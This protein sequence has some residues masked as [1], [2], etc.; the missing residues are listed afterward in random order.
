VTKSQNK[1]ASFQF[2]YEFQQFS[3]RSSTASLLLHI[4]HNPTNSDDSV[5]FT[6]CKQR[7]KTNNRSNTLSALIASDK[8]IRL[9]RLSLLGSANVLI[10]SSSRPAAANPVKSAAPLLLFAHQLGDVSAAFA[11]NGN[12][13]SVH[14]LRKKQVNK[15]P[16][17]D[18]VCGQSRERAH[19]TGS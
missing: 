17:S 18:H 10:K 9:S 7:R 6:S 2:S 19:Q 4:P 3:L 14:L 5:C 1:A 11:F 12:W 16:F 15:K 13:H 8:R